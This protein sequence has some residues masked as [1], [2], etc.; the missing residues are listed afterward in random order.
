MGAV[1]GVLGPAGLAEMQAMSAR[2][3]HRGADGAEWS[4]GP[5]MH[6]GVR[7]SPAAVVRQRQGQVAF[8]GA[9]DN[10]HELA[11]RLGHMMER[12]DAARDAKLAAELWLTMG[13]EGLALIAGQFAFALWDPDGR[14]LV[15]ARDRVGYAPLY[16]A[17]A[18]DRLVFASEYKALLAIEAIPARPDRAALQTIHNTKWVRPGATCLEGIYPVAPG[19]FL[20][21]RGEGISS[22]RYW[23]IPVHAAEGNEAAHAARLRESFLETLRMQLEPYQRIGISLSGGLD[24]AVVAAGVRAVA[25][26]REVHTFSAGYGPDDRELVNAGIVAR[27]LGTAHHPVVLDPE[28]LPTLLPWMVWHLEEP[29]GREDIAYLFVAAREAARHADLVVTGFGFDGLFAGLPRH[30]LVDLGLKHPYLR[31]PLEEF[32]DYTYRSVEPRTLAGRALK[33]A[34]FRGREFPVPRIVGA[35]ALAPFG[36]FPHGGEQPLTEFLKRGFMV[37]PYQ[38]PIER[39]Y[40]GAGLRM[41]AQHTNPGFLATA[42]SIPDALKIR[43]RK[44]KYILRRACEGLISPSILATGKSFNRLK[45]DAHMSGVLDRMA[46]ELLSP[47]AVRARR[48]FEPAY[49]SRLRRRA[50][51]KPYSQ[52]RA[53]RLWSMLLTEMWARLY[54]DGRGAAPVHALPAVRRLEPPAAPGAAPRER[55]EGIRAAG[56]SPPSGSIP[57]AG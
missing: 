49:L 23:D 11:R 54:L 40:A 14:R 13:A 12:N 28:D 43:G 16:F 26:S 20:E 17:L 27:E 18:D 36:G 44:Q 38:H 46:D 6:L 15:L 39:L 7:G 37:L 47:T 48:L 45:H 31:R 50:P 24:S 9:I 42:F 22:R 4:P 1:Y 5:D 41:N 55:P 32:F 56:T 10:R 3:A 34:Y 35:P 8:D 33:S 21:A 52:E 19:T 30:R 57:R 51:G 53:Y 29:I 25:G 2:L